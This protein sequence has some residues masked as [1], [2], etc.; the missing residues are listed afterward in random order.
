LTRISP[1]SAILTSQPGNG[2]PIVPTL[3]SSGVEIVAAV[4]VSVIPQPSSTST[5]A[6]SKKRRISGLIGAAPETARRILPPNRP[7]I[8]DRTFLSAKSYWRCSRN[9][10]W[11]PLRSTS[12][13]FAPVL[14]AQSKIFFLRPPSFSIALVAAV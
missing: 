7:R 13:I 1:S 4:E 2:L 10:G 11:R 14:I 9:P 3:K 6:A 12:R 5:P 8:F